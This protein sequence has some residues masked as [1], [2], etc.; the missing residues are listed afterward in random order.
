M[1]AKYIRTVFKV[2]LSAFYYMS[3]D[4]AFQ[5]VPT[6][7]TFDFDTKVWQK[8]SQEE[9]EKKNYQRLNSF[10]VVLPLTPPN[11]A[12]WLDKQARYSLT[13]NKL[14]KLQTSIIR[15]CACEMG[16][17]PAESTITD[18]TASVGGNTFDF[19][20]HFAH[21][22][23]IELNKDTAQ[24][25]SHNLELLQL[26]GKVTVWQGDCTNITGAAKHFRHDILFLDPPWLGE[27][28]RTYTYLSLYLSGQN[29]RKVCC[30]WAR[31]GTKLI[32]LKLPNNFNYNEFLYE[33]EK[34]PFTLMYSAEIGT[35]P[36]KNARAIRYG[37]GEARRGFRCIMNIAI[38]CAR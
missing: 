36:Q 14:A 31:S 2:V 20:N 6:S 29:V 30:D 11:N 26:S 12:F 8:L 16:M 34:L 3:A 28:Y 15:M 17:K 18:G 23:A 7:H 21:V 33:S 27:N 37:S 13:A 25:L 24:M 35:D 19:V 22:N 32:A 9:K 1:H 38:L 5:L 4:G 10:P